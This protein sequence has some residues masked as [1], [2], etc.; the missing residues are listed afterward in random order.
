MRKPKV[1][2][3]WVK[4]KWFYGSWQEVSTMS[5]K[6]LN[7]EGWWRAGNTEDCAASDRRGNAGCRCLQHISVS[8]RWGQNYL[9][10]CRAVNWQTRLT[11]A[12]FWGLRLPWN[13][14]YYVVYRQECRLP[15]SLFFLLS[16]VVSL[17][18]IYLCM[19]DPEQNVFCFKKTVTIFHGSWIPL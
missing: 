16:L 7:P 4:Y 19:T 2:T 6:L 8:W 17:V 12:C 3:S 11:F 1:S 9:W 5:G 13:C 18:A 14:S 15:H 10:L